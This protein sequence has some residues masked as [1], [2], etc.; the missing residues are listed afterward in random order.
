MHRETSH[1]THRSRTLVMLLLAM[2]IV[3]VFGIA[4]QQA[5]AKGDGSYNHGGAV[6]SSCHPP[7]PPTNAKCSTCHT[8]YAT[9]AS[10]KT[11]WT[12]HTPGQ[13]MASVKSGAPATCTAVCHLANGT[14][15]THNPHPARG[16]CTTCHALTTSVTNANGSPHHT[17]SAP[18]APAVTSF[19]PLSGPVGTTVTITGTGFSATAASNQVK[20]NNGT[21]VTPTTA[22]ATQLTAVVPAGA[23]DGPISVTVAGATGTSVASFDVTTA[24][25]VTPTVTIKSAATVRVN[26]LITISGKVTPTSLA[27]ASVKITIQKKSGTKWKTVKTASAKVSL[28]GAYSYKYKPTSKGTYHTKG[29]IAAKAGVNKAASSIWKTFKAN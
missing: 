21:A 10:G 28:A 9:L 19:T 3:T 27:G 11:C 4:A 5:L 7:Y 2:A 18:A 23:T 1:T 16:V 20:F 29:A 26:K 8:G 24:V 25:V 13:A 12:C 22:S 15:N 17:L 14:D 6:C